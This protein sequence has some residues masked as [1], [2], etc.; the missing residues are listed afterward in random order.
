MAIFTE[1]HWLFLSFVCHTLWIIYELQCS[2]TILVCSYMCLTWDDNHLTF[3]LDFVNKLGN[4]RGVCWPYANY[5][6]HRDVGLHFDRTFSFPDHTCSSH[7]L[8]NMTFDVDV[9]LTMKASCVI[10]LSWS[11]QMQFPSSQQK[12]EMLWY[13]FILSCVSLP[14]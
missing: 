8:M 3:S 4:P 12:W 10:F 6:N 14:W 13:S 11:S 1:Q 9:N 7:S 5:E 2:V